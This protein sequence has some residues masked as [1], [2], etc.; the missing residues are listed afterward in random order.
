MGNHFVVF[1]DNV[2][3]TYFVTQPKLTP[4]QARWQD[5]L[6][7]FDF[8]LRYKPS[9]DNVVMDAFSQR[10]H[11][12]SAQLLSS[13][14]LMESIKNGYSEDELAV[15]FLAG[16]TK[17]KKHISVWD[18]L[19]L[20]KQRRLYVP[21][22]AGLRRSL[23]REHHDTLWAGHPGQ[24]KTLELVAQSFYWPYVERDVEAYVRTCNVCL[25]DKAERRRSAGLLKPLP[26]PEGPWES[27]S[28]DFITC[29]PPSCEYTGIFVVVDRLTKYAHFIPISS[30]CEAEDTA[31][32]FFK[33]VFKYHGLP[34]EIVNDRDS[35]FTGNFWSTL[36]ALAGTTL[37]FSFSYH[38]ET[39]GQTE[40]VN[41]ILQ[42]YLRHYVQLD[43]RDW[44]RFLDIAEYS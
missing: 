25:Q 31:H 27:I 41:Q 9:K 13:Y 7:G 23:L 22:A 6:A 37:R 2:T 3:T 18:G 36:F 4:K 11:L 19:I 32:H 44:S 29:L 16:D 21:A 17:T 40:R 34:R 12:A 20:F 5:F 33:Y 28:M 14:E 8:E 15:S 43:Q 1:T 35:R 26:I 42:D 30:P 39:D 38:P 24:E 10:A